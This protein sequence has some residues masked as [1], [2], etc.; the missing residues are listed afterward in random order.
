VCVEGHH[1]SGNVLDVVIR[2]KEKK[3]QKRLA[4]M[5]KK[6]SERDELRQKFAVVLTK[7]TNPSNWNV[8]DLKTW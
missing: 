5:E 3:E 2:A 8:D 1:V 7:G 6:K 4:T